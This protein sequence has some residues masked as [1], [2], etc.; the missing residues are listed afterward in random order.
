MG[1]WQTITEWFSSIISTIKDC[2]RAV[3]SF[4]CAIGN[5]FC[6]LFKSVGHFFKNLGRMIVKYKNQNEEI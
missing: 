6:Y 2:W 1:F 5:F 3:K 4:F